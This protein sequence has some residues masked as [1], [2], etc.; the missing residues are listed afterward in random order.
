[1]MQNKSRFFTEK[2]IKI[3]LTNDDG[4][5]PYLALFKETSKHPAYLPPRNISA[6]YYLLLVG[7]FNLL[8]AM[9][10]N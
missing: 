5:W 1:F 7:V 9:P 6:F 8:G 2:K 4:A 10:I 3:T